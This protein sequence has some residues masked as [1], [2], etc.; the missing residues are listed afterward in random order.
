MIAFYDAKIAYHDYWL[1]QLLEFLQTE[2]KLKDTLLLVTADHGEEFFDHRGWSHGHSL[3]QELIHV[4]LVMW[5]EG[6][7]PA[8][9][10][11][12]TPVSLLDLFPTLFYLLGLN[13][14]ISLA[15]PLEG[16]DLS[17]ALGEGREPEKKQPICSEL[18]Q[19]SQRAWSL[20]SYPWKIIHSVFSSEEVTELYNLADDPQ[21]KNDLSA[22][23]PE[24]TM[25]LLTSLHKIINLAGQKVF[26]SQRRWIS[27]AEKEKLR[28]LGY[29]D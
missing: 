8:G 19:G 1:G 21:E 9:L 7:L 10:K 27:P 14:V 17:Q 23:Y 12:S 15:Y 5:G 2:N 18:T 6:W 26:K 3:Y 25:K 24:E 16:E 4:P 20:V 28:S 11:I 13:E 22:T 29:I